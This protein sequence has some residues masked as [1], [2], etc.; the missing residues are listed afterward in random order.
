M[1]LSPSSFIESPYK[2]AKPVRHRFLLLWVV[3]WIPVII[4]LGRSF[5][6]QVVLGA[7]FRNRAENN[8]VNQVTLIAPR[9]IIYDRNHATLVENVPSTDLLFD[10]VLLPSEENETFLIENL[11]TLLPDIPPEE[12][13]QALLKARRIQQPVH[14]AK[15]LDHETVLRLEEAGEKI[16]GTR[17]ASSLVRKYPFSE[18]TAHVLGYTNTVTSE[19]LEKTTSLHPT[20]ITGKQGIE[21]SYD[22]ILRGTN[23]AQLVE[24]NAA[25][26][27]QTDLGQTVAVPGQDLELTLDIELQSFIYSL[28]SERDAKAQEEGK[29]PVSGAAVVMDPRSGEVLALVS[30]PSYNPNTFSQP[31]LSKDSA[32]Y[33]EDKLTPL[34]NRVVDGTFASGSVIKPF[35]AAGALQEGIITP[36]TTVLST[37]GIAIGPWRFPDWK[38]GGHGVTDVKKAIAESVNTFFY[39]ITGGYEGQPGLGVEKTTAYLRQ[40]GWA[41]AT[42]IDL[43]S[44][45]DGFLPSKEWKESVKKEPWYIGDT[46]H[47]GIG[48]GDVL[49]TPLQIAT[50][51]TALANGS[52]IFQPHFVRREDIGEQKIPINPAHIQT[53]REGMRQTV[54]DGSAR[55]LSQL[56]VNLA[57]KT[58]TAQVG[59]TDKTHAWF[60]SFGPYE[61][62]EIVVTILLEKG[63]AGDI[64]AVPVAREI[65]NWWIDNKYGKQGE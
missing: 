21:K 27:P 60:T 13:Q 33:F 38:A 24:I 63:G 40:F 35:I 31:A 22:S 45:A 36:Q 39:M 34:F 11:R 7:D 19:E 9:G 37:G 26:R 64:D 15:A 51:T 2:A 55:S 57:G 56:S 65:W 28:F 29:D 46:Y 54:T 59:G 53:I 42:G 61:E 52:T 3:L 41:K 20:D 58:G 18:F 8:R 43:P 50:S 62:P 44:E 1:N 23:G 32:R 5:Y 49:A 17:L 48:Q 14:I 10:P 4:L 16:Q 25:G 47:L 30:Y 6:L 12:L